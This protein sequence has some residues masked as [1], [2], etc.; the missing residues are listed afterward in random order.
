MRPILTLLLCFVLVFSSCTKQTNCDCAPDPYPPAYGEKWKITKVSGGIGNVNIPL[1]DDQK[2][3]VLVLHG[4]GSFSCR[5]IMTG[6]T[7]SGIL[8]VSNFNSI[9]GPVQ[10][11][12]FSPALPMTP[13]DPL[14]L[15]STSNQ[16]M[17]FGE[18][19]TDPFLITFEYIP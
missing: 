18:N 11:Y 15:I 19:V 4:N 2:N 3:N 14:L 12:Q 8:T 7:V 16:K 1:T 9:F 10:R 13:V 17:V 5:N 6:A